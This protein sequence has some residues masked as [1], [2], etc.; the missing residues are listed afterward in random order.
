M[1]FLAISLGLHFCLFFGLIKYLPPLENSSTSTPIEIVFN[2][3]NNSVKKQ[4]VSDPDLGRLAEKIKKQS[5][6]LSRLTRRVKEESVAAQTGAT[7]NRVPKQKT[8][9]QVVKNKNDNK[10]KKIEIKNFAESG[11]NFSNEQKESFEEK[12]NAFSP[13]S[14]IAE[15]I[16]NVKKGHF[17][18]LNTDQFTYYA[19]FNRIN[20]QIRVRWTNN[21]R[22]LSYTL[23]AQTISKLSLFARETKVELVLNSKGEFIN[24][25][26]DQSSGAKFLDQ[27]PIDAFID[28]TPFLNP[29]QDLV[30]QDGFIRLNYS[31][32]VEWNPSYIAKDRSLG[33]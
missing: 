33:N 21:I 24:A 23:P 29:P 22:K 31:F 11:L 1:L 6:R 18:V 7:K 10:S 32:Y 3:E 30:D 26:V 25:F 13:P 28:A 27:A 12:T 2:N 16:P 4:F 8:Q 15:H 19:F 20:E 17:T 5:Q 14:T 9:Q